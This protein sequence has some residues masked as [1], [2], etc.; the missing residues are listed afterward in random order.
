LGADGI[1]RCNVYPNPAR[2]SATVEF[3]EMLTGKYLLE[4][5]NGKGC[6]FRE[7]K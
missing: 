7:K 6:L 1:S 5:M 3:D 4:L 2:R